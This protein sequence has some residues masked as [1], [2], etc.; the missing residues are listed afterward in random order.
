[1]KHG[2]Q[3]ILPANAETMSGPAVQWM[4]EQAA[5]KPGPSWVAW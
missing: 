4:T 5:K 3:R 1:M 2:H